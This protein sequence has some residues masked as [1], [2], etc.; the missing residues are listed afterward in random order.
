MTQV[1]QHYAHT[2][3]KFK[4][5]IHTESSES[6]T[7]VHKKIAI[8]VLGLFKKVLKL[9]LLLFLFSL[10]KCISKTRQATSMKFFMVIEI[11]DRSCKAY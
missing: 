4:F 7:G 10:D 1:C 11:H 9:L 6:K 3:E 8:L 5:H 2:F